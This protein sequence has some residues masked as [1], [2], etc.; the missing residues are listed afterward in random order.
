M[1]HAPATP[2]TAVFLD[3]ENLLYHLKTAYND[4]PQVN[5]VVLEII[6]S[7]KIYLTEKLGILPII[8][9]AYADFERLATVPLGSLYLMGIDTM[10]VLGTEHKNAADM[11]LCIDLMEVLYTR[12]DMSHFVLVAGDRDYIPIVQHL[13]KQAKKVTAVAFRETLSGDLLEILG[14]ENLLEADILMSESSKAELLKHKANSIARIGVKIVGKIEI[15]TT[16]FSKTDEIT[17]DVAPQKSAPEKNL[18]NGKTATRKSIKAFDPLHEEHHFHPIKDISSNDALQC[19][20]LLMN[21]LTE[22]GLREVWLSP[23]LRHLT[24]QMPFLAD[25]ERKELIAKLEL[26][27]AIKVEKREGDPYP[28]SVIIIN[29]NHKNVKELV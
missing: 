9:K 6:R 15:P 18:T 7:L 27:G 12:P 29:Y 25:Y 8:Y 16:V 22:K 21:F 1:Q 4:P 23:F 2:Y 28:Y 13:R 3:F 26:F 24:D 11:R 14:K 20:K 5:E 19:L 17:Q 10:N